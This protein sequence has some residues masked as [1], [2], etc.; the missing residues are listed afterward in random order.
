MRSAAK[1][2]GTDGFDLA[3]LGDLASM[4]DGPVQSN[5]AVAF[6]DVARIHEDENNAR[7]ADNPGFSAESIQEFAKLIEFKGI[8]V[9]LS[10]RPHPTIPGDFIINHGHR[11]FRAAMIAGLQKVPAFVDPDF[12]DDDG[13]AE[14]LQRE[15]LTFREIADYIGAKISKGCTQAEIAR[16]L[17][18]SK[19]WVSQHAAVLSLPEPIAAAMASGTVTDVTLA[20][21]LA[22][23]HR[24]APAAVEHLLST[25]ERR[26][27]RA[28][29]KEIR[30]KAKTKDASSTPDN[31]QRK[32]RRPEL[33][34]TQANDPVAQHSSAPL[35]PVQLRVDVAALL[36]LVAIAK[37]DTGQSKRVADFL[38]GWWNAASC[39]GFDLT[40]LWA[41]DA[42]IADDLVTV[43]HLIRRV[44]AYPDTLSSE[45][46]AEF[47]A[48]VKLWRPH[49]Q[50][51]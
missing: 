48:L 42:E 23:A 46:H 50:E 14:N 34:H 5:G 31:A 49:L 28:A 32:A 27:T 17:G 11:R 1:H 19:A 41:M 8:K 22:S 20:S 45:I 29:V 2:S 33:P 36:R 21:E 44:R 6:Y 4:L 43:I 10:L 9:P 37:S 39:G 51:E 26:P 40:D 38:L 30:Q 12:D 25:G 3:G 13:V 15:N 35:S 18:K 7:R 24:E 47:K 16:A